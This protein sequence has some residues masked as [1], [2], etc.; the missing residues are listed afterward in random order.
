MAGVAPRLVTPPVTVT[1]SWPSKRP[2]RTA[3]GAT[4]RLGASTSPTDTGEKVVPAG[5][6]WSSVGAQPFFWKS[7]MSTT[8]LRGRVDSTA[9]VPATFSAGA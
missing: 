9:I 2:R 7:L 4:E 5:S 3:T 6:R 1:R 8:S